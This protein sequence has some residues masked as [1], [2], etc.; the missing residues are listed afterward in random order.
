MP[1]TTA[2]HDQ[3]VDV[4]VSV[5]GCEPDDV[6]PEATLK[7]LGADSLTVVE[8][9]E[10]LEQRF[11]ISLSDATI[12]G[13]VT[14]QDALEAVTTPAEPVPVAAEPMPELGL[15]PDA[16]KR[17]WR[18]VLWMAVV[19]VLL[20]GFFGF[21]SSGAVSAL[22]LG[23]VDLPP[24]PSSAKSSATPTPTPTP[25]PTKTTAPAT[26]EPTL[27][28]DD[29]QVSPGQRFRL[30]G[31]FPELG[32]DAPLVIE[33]RENGGP[34][35]AFPVDTSTRGQGEFAAELYTSR[36][37]PREFRVRHEATDQTT[38]TV[39]VQIG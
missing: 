11:G 6:V 37:G 31:R 10:G 27:S 16:K 5:L 32:A 23:S 12:D 29:P 17:V 2:A 36:T 39:A 14:V 19:G 4:V 25:T 28:V 3:I 22:G 26:P 38:P 20:G 8:I 33:F 21:F 1:T 13:L 9:G 15:A 18:T 35:E 24:L 34:W 30:T 7:E